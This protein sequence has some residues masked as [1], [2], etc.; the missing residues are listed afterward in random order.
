MRRSVVLLLLAALPAL[1]DESAI[2]LKDAPGRE[3]A[4]KNCVACHSLDYI[5]MN[6]PFL[7]RK[8]WEGSVTKMIKV[9]GAPIPDAD[10]A[11][12]V[13]YLARNYGKP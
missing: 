10:V 11:G 6:S 5:P 1:A 8:G 7:D 12:L 3:L 2:K 13:D 4:E 9:M